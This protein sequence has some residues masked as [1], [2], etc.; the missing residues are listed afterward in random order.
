MTCELK[1]RYGSLAGELL[2]GADS[3]PGY[4]SLSLENLPEPPNRLST[5]ELCLAWGRAAEERDLTERCS[6]RAG[7][8]S[9][10]PA[11]EHGRVFARYH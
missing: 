5:S 3:E 7:T 8:A 9:V 2:Q 11:A 10:A 6:G 4:F 1:D